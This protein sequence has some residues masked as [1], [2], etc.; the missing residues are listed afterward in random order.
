MT[1]P[2]DTLKQLPPLMPQFLRRRRAGLPARAQLMRDLGLD[3]RTMSVLFFLHQVQGSYEGHPVTI[4]Q[5]RAYEPYSA[6]DW[7]TAPLGVF[8]EKGLVAVDTGG[9][10]T[11]TP[12]G[13]EAMDDLHAA[14]RQ[15]VSQLQ[16]LPEEELE[17]LADQLERATAGFIADPVLSPR[18]GSH[19]EGA[20]SLRVDS[21]T[22]HAMVRIEQA[23]Y[24][25]WGARDD[26][27]MKAWR[28]AGLEGPPLDVLTRLW[29][30]EASTLAGLQ[31]VLA[32]EQT[33]TDIDSSLAY[34][35]D[36]E[37]I[38]RDGDSVQLTPEGVLVREDIERDTDKLYFDPWPHTTRDARWVLGAL[39]RLIDNLPTPPPPPPD[40]TQQSGR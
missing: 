2:L 4:S 15:H 36:K 35:L 20:R 33:P 12:R 1:Q 8:L 30:G 25:L 7:C 26:A 37:Y 29:T 17:T 38:Q 40:Q 22:L 39:R 28:D 13:R 11:L 9:A 24:E 6:I 19:L 16:P 10:Y 3:P 34:L 5:L 14:G 32:D 21:D 27:H 31:E 18:P 23:I